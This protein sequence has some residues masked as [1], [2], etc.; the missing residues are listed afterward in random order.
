MCLVFKAAAS[1]YVLEV[2]FGD[3]IPVLKFPSMTACR[4]GQIWKS[5]ERKPISASDKS[6]EVFP[7]MTDN[8]LFYDSW[9]YYFT[10][11]RGLE[12]PLS[13]RVSLTD[14]S[15][16]RD[17]SSPFPGATLISYT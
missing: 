16:F 15:N 11:I 3:G 6:R 9:F 10:N 2:A 12:K 4:R 17:A 1:L 7:A 14:A 13:F 5:G 8:I